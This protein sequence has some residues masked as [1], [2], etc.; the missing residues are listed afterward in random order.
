MVRVIRDSD[1]CVTPVLSLEEAPTIHTI[2]RAKPS[3][4]STAWCNPHPPRASAVRRLRNS[5]RAGVAGQSGGNWL[6]D[7]GFSAEE[8][9]RLKASG[10]I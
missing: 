4:K 9:D 1:A 7:W 8:I 10:A 6:A 5:K 2:K 3:S